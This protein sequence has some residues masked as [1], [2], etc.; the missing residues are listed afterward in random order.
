M[1]ECGCKNALRKSSEKEQAGM[2]IG[3][4]YTAAN[5]CN[6]KREPYNRQAQQTSLLVYK[7]NFLQR[8]HV[9]LLDPALTHCHLSLEWKAALP[10]H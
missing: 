1:C 2:K 7:Q 8:F 3:L 9:L 4:C 10:G 6:L 5:E